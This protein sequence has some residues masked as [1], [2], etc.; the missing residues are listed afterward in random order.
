MRYL[1][2]LIIFSLSAP[3]I[4]SA[5]DMAAVKDPDTVRCRAIKELG[6]R[7]P[8]RVCKTNAEWARQK[9]EAREAIEKRNRNSHCSGDFC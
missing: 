3:A 8:A 1:F 2:A 6:S 9:A 7:I 5:E 4:A